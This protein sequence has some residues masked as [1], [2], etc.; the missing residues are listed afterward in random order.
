MYVIIVCGFVLIAAVLSVI[1]VAQ[2]KQIDELNGRIDALCMATDWIKK[3][4]NKLAQICADTDTR[5][6]VWFDQIEADLKDIRK[7]NDEISNRYILYKDTAEDIAE[8]TIR[9]LAENGGVK[10]SKTYRPK[11]DETDESDD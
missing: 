11:E 10:W 5:R 2:S 4:Q 7:K 1:L 3:E 6:G 8:A 9:K